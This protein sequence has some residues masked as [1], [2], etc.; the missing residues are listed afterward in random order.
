RL[1]KYVLAN[2]HCNNRCWYKYRIGFSFSLWMGRIPYPNGHQRGGMGKLDF[3][4]GYGSDGFL[5]P[6]NKNRYQSCFKP[7]FS[8]GNQAT[9]FNE[10]ESLCKNRRSKCYAYTC[11]SRSGKS[12]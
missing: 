12:G 4:N 11:N 2:D 7:Q 8:T 3:S 5:L 1:A 9:N 10:S 6:H